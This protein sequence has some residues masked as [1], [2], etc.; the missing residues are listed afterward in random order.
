MLDNIISSPFQLLLIQALVLLFAADAVPAIPIFFRYFPIFKRFT[1]SSMI[2]AMSRALMYI[3]TSFA[4]E[5]LMNHFGNYGL[6]II[7]IP[8]N[9]AFVFGLFYFEKLEK[10]SKNYPK[11]RFFPFVA[12]ETPAISVS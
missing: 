10:E 2:Y 4:I 7:M 6:L 1:Y 5:F 11:K 12:D 3:V 8:V 9:I